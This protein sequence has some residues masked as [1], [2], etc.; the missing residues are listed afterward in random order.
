MKI[1]AL[2]G[3][4]AAALFL[5][6]EDDGVEWKAFRTRRRNRSSGIGVAQLHGVSGRLDLG[7]GTA[8][9]QN[10]EAEACGLEGLPF[11]SPGVSVRSRRRIQPVAGIGEG[12]AE[13]LQEIGRASCR[14]RW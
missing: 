1:G 6:E 14:G 2:F 4:K 3:K 8:I 9:E 13:N 7:V 10:Q 12:L 5:V 11:S